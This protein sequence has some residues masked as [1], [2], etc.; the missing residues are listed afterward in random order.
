MNSIYD[1]NKPSI[2]IFYYKDIDEDE[3]LEI[4]YGIEEEGIPYDLSPMDYDDINLLSYNA[5]LNSV[6]GVGIGVNRFEISI[7]MEKLDQSS[8]LIIENLDVSA[9][10][11]KNFGSNAARLVKKMPLK[12]IS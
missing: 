7:H 12:D 10:I 2:K 3:M 11:R 1:V 5:S 9:D 6:L 4:L 8:P